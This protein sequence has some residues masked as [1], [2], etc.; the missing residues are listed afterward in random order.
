M[1]SQDWETRKTQSGVCRMTAEA[2]LSDGAGFRIE[3]G[4]IFSAIE[5]GTISEAVFAAGP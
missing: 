4:G 3:I 5:T 2:M 1:I